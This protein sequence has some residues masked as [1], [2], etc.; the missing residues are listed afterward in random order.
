M[1]N[2]NGNGPKF[3][4]FGK[5][6][7]KP[8]TMAERH[9][10]TTEEKARV[11]DELE[12]DVD[13]TT[14]PPPPSS[15]QAS[16]VT[17]APTYF[18]KP[19]QYSLGFRSLDNLTY[20]FN[21]GDFMILGAGTN[22][23]KTQLALYIALAQLKAKVPTLYV[24]RELSNRELKQRFEFL[25]PDLD[26]LHFADNNRLDAAG[27][28]ALI[29]TFNHDHPGG[30]VIVDHIHAFFRGEKLTEA[31]GELSAALREAAQDLHLPILALSQLNRQP[32]KDEEGP[33]N[34]HLKESGY[35]EDDAYSILMCWRIEREFK[36]KLTKSRHRDLSDMETP[37]ISLTAGGGKL[38][39]PGANLQ[40]RLI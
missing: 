28:L 39:D 29:Q 23:G 8:Q 27:L 10:W 12:H 40:E 3:I 20:G 35:L 21:R 22:Q 5:N 9:R 32:Y 26:N 6:S 18:N 17:S 14:P 24:S 13:F 36:I 31:L 15:V 2:P 1:I 38:V 7:P 37:I 33:Y 19:G 16:S 11:R 25:S 30:F 34:Y 4:R